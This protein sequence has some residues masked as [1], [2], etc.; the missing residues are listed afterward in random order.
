MNVQADLY[1]VVS[2]DGWL[3]VTDPTFSGALIH[4]EVYQ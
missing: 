1:A 2:N 3:T 4:K